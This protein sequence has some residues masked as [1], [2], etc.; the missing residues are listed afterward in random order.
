LRDS[1]E[2]LLSIVNNYVDRNNEPLIKKSEDESK[3]TLVL[4]T[5]AL[6][7]FVDVD[8]DAVIE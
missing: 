5:L 8:I 4:A 7:V 2:N 3:E 1:I 6:I